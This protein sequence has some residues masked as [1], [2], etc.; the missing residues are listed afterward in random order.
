MI[1]EVGLSN[2][3]STIPRTII[4]VTARSTFMDTMGIAT[5]PAGLFQRSSPEPIPGGSAAPGVVAAPGFVAAPE[6]VAALKV[7]A[8][9]G[10]GAAPGVVAT[11]G[12]VAA[13]EVVA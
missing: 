10:V 13:A 8:A 11:P 3:W 1:S 7:V 2:S 12:V 9:P 5:S 6:V 4:P